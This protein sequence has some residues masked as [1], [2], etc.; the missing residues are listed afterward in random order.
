ML[1]TVQCPGMGSAHLCNEGILSR[2]SVTGSME[3]LPSGS[4]KSFLQYDAN[5]GVGI[6]FIRYLIVFLLLFSLAFFDY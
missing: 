5:Y 4:D 2:P 1:I 3:Y 6:P